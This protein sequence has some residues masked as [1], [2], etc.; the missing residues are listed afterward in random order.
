MKICWDNL[1]N[2][3]YCKKDGYFRRRYWGGGR[4][5]PEKM[6]YVEKCTTCG[7]PFLSRL[8]TPSP[9][10]YCSTKCAKGLSKHDR[11]Y[12]QGYADGY[13]AALN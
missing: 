4:L 7:E 5:R 6:I 12:Q 11:I 8:S 2:V 10:Q 1:E 9:Q 13:A 3:T